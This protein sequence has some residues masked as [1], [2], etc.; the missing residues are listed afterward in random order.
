MPFRPKPVSPGKA[1]S[2]HFAVV[3]ALAAKLPGVE[4]STSYGTPALK[5]KGKLFARL[6]EDGETPVVRTTPE[7]RE[8]LLERWPA[9]FHLTEHY[10]DYPWV[11]IRLTKIRRAHLA[12]VLEDAW[13]RVAPLSLRKER[14]AR[15]ERTGA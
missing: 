10:R 4:E 12:E 7:D 1:P 3:C 6:R 5:V 13:C 15:S 2:A 9:V 14:K 8:L 11:L